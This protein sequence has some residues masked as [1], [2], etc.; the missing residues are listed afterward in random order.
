LAR[1]I[2]PYQR[3]GEVVVSEAIY[4]EPVRELLGAKEAW[5]QGTAE[6]G[7][8]GGDEGKGDDQDGGNDDPPNG[9]SPVLTDEAAA[10]L[11]LADLLRSPH[12]GGW[13]T[14]AMVELR[15]FEPLTPS[16]RTRCATGLRHSPGP[17]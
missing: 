8:L 17:D 16:M 13:N 1:S 4:T 11:A 12:E 6:T 3:D 14:A 5:R 7:G 10:E 9:S 2:R 15:G